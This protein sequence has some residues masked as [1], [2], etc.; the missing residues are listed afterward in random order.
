MAKLGNDVDAYIGYYR[1]LLAKKMGGL[2]HQSGSDTA[3]R[4]MTNYCWKGGVNTKVYNTMLADITAAY[5]DRDKNVEKTVRSIIAKHMSELM[6]GRSV[7]R[8]QA[9]YM[10]GGG[11]LKRNSYGSIRKCSVNSVLLNDLVEENAT[12]S[13]FTWGNVLNHYKK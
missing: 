12:R 7:T 6:K 13:S 2:E 3:I 8:N 5:C 9:Q 4:Y 1:N 11:V 10:L